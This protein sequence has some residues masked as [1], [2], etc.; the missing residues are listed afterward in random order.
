MVTINRPWGQMHDVRALINDT[1]AILQALAQEDLDEE[2]YD[3]YDRTPRP[4]GPL[5]A[6]I[7]ARGLGL[8]G[9]SASP[10]RYSE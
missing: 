10:P 7:S 8:A 3:P 2:D 6:A 1:I 9:G 4:P 5:D